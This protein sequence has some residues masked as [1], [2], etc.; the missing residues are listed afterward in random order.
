MRW[1]I[2]GSKTVFRAISVQKT[3]TP[4]ILSLVGIHL[5]QW[6]SCQSILV[7]NARESNSWQGSGRWRLCICAAVWGGACV[8]DFRV[9]GMHSEPHQYSEWVCPVSI[10][11]L[12]PTLSFHNAKHV[13][14]PCAKA[15]RQINVCMCLTV[16]FETCRKTA[17]WRRRQSLQ[18]ALE[19]QIKQTH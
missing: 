12:M 19:M 8:C 1:W 3:T 10:R 13:M 17:V 6:T 14:R 4:G 18:S 9:G 7:I 16:N 15:S 2:R 11:P 5:T